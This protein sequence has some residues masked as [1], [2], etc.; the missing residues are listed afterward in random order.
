MN[1]NMSRNTTGKQSDKF[2]AKAWKREDNVGKAVDRLTREEVEQVEEANMDTP[3]NSYK[4]QCAV[5]VKHSKLGEG[6]TLYSQHAQ[7]DADGNI[8]WY[9]VM[10]EEGIKR[11]DTT[12]LEILESEMHGNHK[13]K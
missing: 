9:D 11:V 3:G 4:H 8:A 12:D 10:F 13:K 1:T 7:P 5:H 2:A 6:K